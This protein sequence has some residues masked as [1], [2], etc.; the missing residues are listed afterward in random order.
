MQPGDQAVL[1]FVVAVFIIF[2]VIMA[3]ATWLGGAE[4]DTVRTNKNKK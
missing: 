3:Y 2:S 4:K 1:G